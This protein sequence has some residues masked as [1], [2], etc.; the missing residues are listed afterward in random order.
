MSN[1]ILKILLQIANTKLKK[2]NISLAIYA[3]NLAFGSGKLVG[4]RVTGDQSQKLN[5][6][7][8]DIESQSRMSAI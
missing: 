8:R 1:K 3:H 5:L 4:L 6:S 2:M 7:Y